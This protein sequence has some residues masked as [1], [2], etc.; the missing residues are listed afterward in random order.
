ME[1]ILHNVHEKKN[2]SSYIA[3]LQKR[4]RIFIKF[5]LLDHKSKNL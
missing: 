2:K 3:E 4:Q 1:K 5:S